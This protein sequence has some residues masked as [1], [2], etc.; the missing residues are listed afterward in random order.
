MVLSLPI[1][2]LARPYTTQSSSDGVLSN[3]ITEALRNNPFGTRSRSE[4]AAATPDERSKPEAKELN[5]DLETLSLIFPDVKI[6]VFRE[7]LVRFQGDS[8]LRVC[9]DQLL[10]NKNE[11]V[12]GRWNVQEG[13]TGGNADADCPRDINAVVP[14]HERFRSPEYKSAVKAA[15]V[16]EFNVLS[17]STV[18]AVLAEVNFDY[19]RAR[20]TLHDL[21]RKTWRAAINNILPFRSKRERDPHHPLIVWQR[22][23]DEIIPQLKETGCVELD[24][25]L[26]SALLVPLLRANQEAREEND[27]L[28]AQELNTHEA[29]M[30]DALFE[31][32]CCLSDVT[33][34]QIATCS[35]LCHVICYA[36]IRRTV[37]EALFGQGWRQSVDTERSTLKCLA[38]VAEPCPGSLN[39]DVVK[40]AILLD[41][42][43]FETYTKFET[44]LASDALVMTQLKLIRCPSCAYAEVDPAHHPP[45]GG[46]RWR[47]RR[48]AMSFSTV[49]ITLLLLD[50]IGLLMIPLIVIHLRDPTTLPSVWRNSITNLYLKYR[51]KKFTCANSLCRQ[52]SCITCQKPWRDP[53]VCHEPLLLDLRATVEAA[54]TAAVKRTCPRC[55]TS[56]V[57]SSGC[58]KLTCVCGYSMCYICRKG[59]VSRASRPD[60]RRG[61]Q[62]NIRMIG[63]GMVIENRAGAV[64]G[65]FEAFQEEIDDGY[66]HFCEHFRV[67]PGAKCN[68]CNK[69]EL[70]QDEDEEA[71]ARRAGAKAE[72]EWHA[73]QEGA[74]V[75]ISLH[76]N[77]DFSKNDRGSARGVGNGW[78]YWLGEAW[79]NGQSL[80]DTL[81]ERVVVIEQL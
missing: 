77:H 47:F 39:S 40:Q 58:N 38:P 78:S 43:G 5:D 36:C 73:R 57:K 56:F 13:T 24:Q 52:V 29:K 50:L 18:E 35:E 30:M 32:E 55:G 63:G 74:A 72:R 51:P 53:H 62:E 25:E 12:A 68:Q 2:R 16:K 66:H 22:H 6:E 10:R 21:S 71:V 20:P 33:F 67:F 80:V 14:P 4:S 42:A 81:V 1:S 64:P 37:H 70:Y 19:L 48:Q 45:E 54:R 17:K 76:V 41:K 65:P 31:C 8:R 44:R 27:Q 11:W 59:L 3:T 7:L 75:G 28:L 46:V 26:H 69:C 34:E 60:G 9:V 79:Q 49:L 61:N 23:A 15:L